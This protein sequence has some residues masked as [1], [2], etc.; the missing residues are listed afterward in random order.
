MPAHGLFGLYWEIPVDA[1]EAGVR[2]SRWS[3]GVRTRDGVLRQAVLD[4]ID[5]KL[6]VTDEAALV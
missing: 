5:L 6:Q 4:L 1:R 2:L 3:N